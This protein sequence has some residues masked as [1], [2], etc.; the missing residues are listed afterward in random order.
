MRLDTRLV[1]SGIPVDGP[2]PRGVT[3]PETEDLAARTQRM[4]RLGRLVS[5]TGDANLAWYG[6]DAL[7]GNPEGCGGP[8]RDLIRRKELLT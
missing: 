3:I 8:S 4:A 2:L 5:Q 1:P 7:D 6:N